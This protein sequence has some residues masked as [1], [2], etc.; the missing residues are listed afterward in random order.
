MTMNTQDLKAMRERSWRAV[1]KAGFERNADLPLLE[2]GLTPQ[3]VDPITD[4]L[5]CM[6]LVAAHAFG[7]P[8]GKTLDWLDREGVRET[9]SPREQAF[10]RGDM[11]QHMMC[12][13]Q[14]NGVYA[15]MWSLSAVDTFSIDKKMPDDLINRLP[16]FRNNE[17]S[18][19]FRRRLR[20][21][22][23]PELLQ[24]LDT[25][26]CFHWAWRDAYF[27]GNGG[28]VKG[29]MFAITERRKA[30]EWMFRGGNWDDIPLDT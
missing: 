14:V 23:T 25:G 26:L 7:F 18:A 15:L 19:E 12:Q 5:L 24:Q 11:S 21:R 22:P 29:D 13:M 30:L 9:L 17:S 16:D 20:L 6:A 28:N 8:A 27:S 10:L 3:S 1:E 4:R 2:Q